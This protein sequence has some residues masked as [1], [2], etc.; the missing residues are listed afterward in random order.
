MSRKLTKDD[1]RYR[2]LDLQNPRVV[3]RLIGYEGV[4]DFLT[5]LGFAPDENGIKLVCSKKPNIQV[6]KNAVEVLASYENKLGFSNKK[7]RRQLEQVGPDANPTG[8]ELMSDGATPM[9]PDAN[10]LELAS[11]VQQEEEDN[12]MSID[13]IIAWGT[14]ENA[15]DT[16]SIST[17]IMTHVLYSD[18]LYVLCLCENFGED[19][20]RFLICFVFD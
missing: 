7:K 20:K 12:E 15:R 9:G 13:Q 5:L 18:S 10:A 2:T 14:H 17:L 4:L 19:K 16:D 6:I 3:E 11:T 1:V 8:N